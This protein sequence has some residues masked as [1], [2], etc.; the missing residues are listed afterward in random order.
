[1]GAHLIM[2]STKTREEIKASIER[3]KNIKIR[4]RKRLRLQDAEIGSGR[5]MRVKGN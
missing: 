2:N 5:E 1:M 3:R 4:L